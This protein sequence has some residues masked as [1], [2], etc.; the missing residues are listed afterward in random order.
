MQYIVVMHMKPRQNFCR[1]AK[2]I[3]MA[4]HISFSLCVHVLFGEGNL[5]WSLWDFVK[6]D[7]GENKRQ[8]GM[9]TGNPSVRRI[10]AR[11]QEIETKDSYYT[12]LDYI[13]C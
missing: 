12:V 10:P 7:F 1:F 3:I 9:E 4:L 6:T 2:C 11:Y 5:F 13:I 8:A